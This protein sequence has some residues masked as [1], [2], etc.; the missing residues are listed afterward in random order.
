MASQTG[1]FYA[2]MPVDEAA[3]GAL[4]PLRACWTPRMIRELVRFVDDGCARPN[5]TAAPV[6]EGLRRA[7]RD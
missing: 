1:D 5:P 7:R 3:A 6:A 2:A 4:S